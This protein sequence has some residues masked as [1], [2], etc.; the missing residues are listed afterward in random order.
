M[1]LGEHTLQ[2]FSSLGALGAASGSS[3]GLCA[4]GRVV[5]PSGVGSGEV[6]CRH[7]DGDVVTKGSSWIC[8]GVM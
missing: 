1:T 8:D 7:D 4:G 5:G 2:A 3:S 6:V